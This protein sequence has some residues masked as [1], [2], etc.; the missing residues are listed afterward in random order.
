[1]HPTIDS[2]QLLISSPWEFR[3]YT[4]SDRV[5]CV[6]HCGC[7]F[8]RKTVKG[9]LPPIDVVSNG[10]DD[11]YDEKESCGEATLLNLIY[12]GTISPSKGLP[13]ILAALRKVKEK[14]HDVCLQVAGG[15]NPFFIRQIRSEYKDLD[16]HLLGQL[17]F[18]RL[19]ECYKD[20]DIGIIASLQEQASYVAIEMAMFG[21]P[22]ITTSVDGLDETF[23][24]GIDALKVD[25]PFSKEKGLKVDVE[26][27]ADQIVEL[28]ENK[29]KRLTLG[30]NARNLY[31]TKLTLR[32]M[33]E[34]TVAV[35]RQVMKID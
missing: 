19:K 23:T 2:N 9:K 20:A 25:V 33:M 3:S 6:T 8:V 1:M 34:N 16:L 31:T 24:D 11:F 18:D 29:E 13:F 35:Y 28:I 7:D 30:R 14:G 4:Q 17:P 22:I 27:M 5:I 12:V 26:G 32:C 21:L 10:M 15:G